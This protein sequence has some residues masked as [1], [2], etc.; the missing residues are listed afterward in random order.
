MANCFLK[1]KKDILR[2]DYSGITAYFDTD[3]VDITNGVWKNVLGE[4]YATLTSSYSIV[5]DGN[6]Q[7]FQIAGGYG[8]YKTDFPMTIYTM[9][10]G[11][12][13]GDSWAGFIGKGLTSS[14]QAN[15]YHIYSSSSSPSA[16]AIIMMRDTNTNVLVLDENY[17]VY[18]LSNN[19][20]YVDGVLLNSGNTRP[21]NLY[22]GYMYI[23]YLYRSS[24]VSGRGTTNYKMVAFGSEEHSAEQVLKNSNYLLKTYL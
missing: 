13:V 19:C 3:S 16:S 8:K 17:H 14:G 23:N 7:A 20:A 11:I 18:C 1:R 24:W 4:D 6:K 9:F 21:T 15:D 2:F 22:N 5:S 12:K 10:R